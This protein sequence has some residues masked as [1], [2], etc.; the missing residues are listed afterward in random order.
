MKKIALAVLLSVS[1]L[2][3]S[4]CGESSKKEEPKKSE[5]D[6]KVKET[7]KKDVNSE[8]LNIT[9]ENFTKLNSYK[10]TTKLNWET[11]DSK[12]KFESTTEISYTKENN[13]KQIKISSMNGLPETD[14]ITINNDQYMKMQGQWMKLP[15]SDTKSESNDYSELSKEVKEN[16]SRY[17]FVKN[18]EINGVKCKKYNI[19]DE[20]EVPL[21]ILK[22]DGKNESKMQKVKMTGDVWVGSDGDTKDIVI[23]QNSKIEGKMTNP[24]NMLKGSQEST[25]TILTTVQEMT[26]INKLSKI[27]APADAVS[28]SDA[29]NFNVDQLLSKAPQ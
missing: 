17:K 28:F 12:E 20:V 7:L 15:Q 29:G 13:A 18:E 14:M 24:S 8:L 2:S 10:L 22:A 11:P 3:F 25:D 27:E 23:K 19:D 1:L 5:V 16:S 21:P 6:Q 26:E 4:A 9:D